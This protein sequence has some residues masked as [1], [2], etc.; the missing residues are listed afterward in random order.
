MKVKAMKMQREE[1][2]EESRQGKVE[3]GEKRKGNKGRSA[4]LVKGE[5][6][7]RKKKLCKGRMKE[8]QREKYG[9][10]DQRD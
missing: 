4:M 7:E 10:I 6:R 8:I 2:K 1:D 5:E 3:E 9:N